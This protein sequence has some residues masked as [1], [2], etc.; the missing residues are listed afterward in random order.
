MIH[1]VTIYTSIR[2][3]EPDGGDIYRWYSWRHHSW[4]I[5]LDTIAHGYY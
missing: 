4:C 1:T 3:V 2:L 5:L